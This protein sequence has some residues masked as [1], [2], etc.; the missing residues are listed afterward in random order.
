M[1]ADTGA[2]GEETVL[3]PTLE[4]PLPPTEEDRVL[5][6]KALDLVVPCCAVLK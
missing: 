1:E 4:A 2:A 5:W 6:K 3:E